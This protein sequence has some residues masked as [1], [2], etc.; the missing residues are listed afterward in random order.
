MKEYAKKKAA[1][2][3]ALPDASKETLAAIQMEL[4]KVAQAYGGGAGID[5]TAFPDLKFVDPA[6][7]PIN[8]SS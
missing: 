1:A 7:D 6:V 3:G 2:G 8:I 4:E 5:M